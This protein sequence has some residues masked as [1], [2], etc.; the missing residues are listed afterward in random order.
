VNLRIVISTGV[1]TVSYLLSHLREPET[2]PLHNN[3][4]PVEGSV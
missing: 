2:Y 3:T 1:A 4:R